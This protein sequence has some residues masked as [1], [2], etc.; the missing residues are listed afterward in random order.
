MPKYVIRYGAMRALGVHSVRGNE[1]LERGAK[2]ISRTDRGLEAGEVLCAANDDA[3]GHLDNPPQG[4]VLRRMTSEDAN[5][6]GHIQLQTRDEFETCQRYVEE[7]E[8]KMELVDLEHIFGGGACRRLL[9]VG[10]ASRFSRASS[11]TGGR[12]SD[13]DRNATDRCT[14]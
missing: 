7:L 5:E 9:F 4:Q 12:I 14:G 3:L 2:V 8:L 13:S 6:W 10:R 1:K 11:K